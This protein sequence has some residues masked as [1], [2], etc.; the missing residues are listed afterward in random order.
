VTEAYLT[1]KQAAERLAC[2]TDS[3]L[4][5]IKRGDLEAVQYGRLIRIPEESFAAFLRRHAR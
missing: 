1:P 3:I 2:S 5:A 4:R